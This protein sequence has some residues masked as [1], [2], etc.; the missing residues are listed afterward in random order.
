MLRRLLPLVLLLCALPSSAQKEDW[1]PVTQ[2]DLRLN[3]APGI[4]GAPAIQLYYANYIDDQEQAEFFYRRIKVLNDKG[5]SY[6]DVEIPVPPDCSVSGLKARTIRPDG[7]VVDFTGKPFKKLLL[8]Q[9]GLKILALTFTMPE[10]SVNSIIEYKYRLNI[11]GIYLDNFWTIQHELYTVKESFRMKPFGGMLDGFEKGH[12]VA[13]LTSRMPANVKP[14]QKGDGY[15]LE[16]ENMP[17]FESEGYMPP[18][19]DYKPQIRFFYGGKEMSSADKFWQEAGREWNDEAERFIGRRREIADE[20]ARV[21]AGETDPVRKLRKLY[22]RAQEIRN[23]SYERERTEQ[24]EKRENLK[25][26]QSAADVLAHGYGHREDVDRFFIALARAAG[27]EASVLRVSNRQEHFFDR[28]VLSRRQLDWEVAL[29][30]EGG[31]NYFLDP[32]TRFCPFGFVR[33][34]NTS[35]L[36]LKLDRNGGTFIKVPAA[37]YDKAM[38]RRAAEMTLD[39]AG[40]LKGTITVRFEG[41]EALERRLE[42][43][44]TDDAGRKENLETEA[45]DWLPSGAKLRLTGV[46][47]WQGSEEPL[48]ATFAVELPS[49]AVVA[50]KRLLA[51]AYVFDSKEMAAFQH[52]ERKF[53]VYFPYAFGEAD[54][55]AI[56][57][58]PGE[59]VES[60]PPQQSGSLSYATYLNT[61]ESDGTRLVTHRVLQVNGIFFRVDTYPQV[62]EFFLKVQA[63][64]EQ[65]AVLRSS[66]V[67]ERAK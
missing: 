46:E 54:T 45:Q 51:P 24:E 29:V 67:A 48:I 41:G 38:V 3:A 30:T 17:P 28:G 5:M 22:S 47:G 27:F 2:Q 14:R 53:P 63:G 35:T 60:L 52:A 4:A 16:L 56:K 9:R 23:L 66:E 32:G 33:W 34:M 36:A 50:G 25:P 11:P 42:A 12:Q 64:D 49:Y 57:I 40:S 7:K 55:V 43:L 6:A 58:P 21:L 26:N 19:D 61:T 13:V 18:E 15:E 37:G 20:A 62:R 39:P 59:T 65:R 31:Q 44:D 10:V 8:K 1:L